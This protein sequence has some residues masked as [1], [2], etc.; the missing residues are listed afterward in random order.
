MWTLRHVVG[1]MASQWSNYGIRSPNCCPADADWRNATAN[2]ESS[3][4]VASNA[5][6]LS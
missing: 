3:V 1:E 4:D 5:I 2:A 6:N